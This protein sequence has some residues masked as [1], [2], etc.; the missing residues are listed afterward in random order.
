METNQTLIQH[1]R[2]KYQ[3]KGE[4]QVRRRVSWESF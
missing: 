4:A 1:V 2:G 3:V